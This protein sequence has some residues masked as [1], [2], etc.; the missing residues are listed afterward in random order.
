MTEARE[1]FDDTRADR[2]RRRG[3]VGPT[4]SLLLA[5]GGYA[6]AV[7]L[8]LWSQGSGQR[9]VVAGVTDLTFVL[10]LLGV[11]VIGV[12]GLLAAAWRWLV[13]G[14]EFVTATLAALF[15]IACAMVAVVVTGFAG[16]L[17]SLGM[18]GSY[19][20]VDAPD[21]PMGRQVLVWKKYALHDTYWHV[22]IGGPFLYTEV[23]DETFL[24]EGCSR[25]GANSR[26]GDEPAGYTLVTDGHGR[27]IL[28]IPV[29]YA[30]CDSGGEFRFAIPE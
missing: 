11:G 1:E 15:L 9:L 21:R 16:L 26:Q 23:T 3:W 2:K 10:V 25:P 6:A 12:V 18:E 19:E 17:V 22:Y 4:R 27:N 7:A 28:T 24:N 14:Y 20:I 5:V 8:F 29:E 30:H 13:S